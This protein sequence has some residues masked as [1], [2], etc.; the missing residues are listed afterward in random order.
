M[1][2]DV[3]TMKR[4]GFLLTKWQVMHQLVTTK[5]KQMTTIRVIKGPQ[6]NDFADDEVAHFLGQAYQVTKQS[7]RMGYRLQGK[8]LS[9]KKQVGEMI[10][11]AVALGSMQ[12]ANDGQPIVLLA[13][14]QTVG[15]YPKVANIISADI[16]K[17]VQLSP[18]SNVRFQCVEI[19]EAHEILLKLHY[20]S[21]RLLMRVHALIMER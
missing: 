19:D 1:S 20:E 13:D 12:I 11:E 4:N 3:F 7:D 15:G 9:K 17:F 21:Q 2:S 14:R 16:S 18:D 6:I 10:S 5:K 8:P